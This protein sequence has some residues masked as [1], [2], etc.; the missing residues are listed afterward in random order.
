MG[1]TEERIV[2]RRLVLGFEMYGKL[3]DDPFFK[4]VLRDLFTRDEL[5]AYHAL[6]RD[7]IQASIVL[8]EAKQIREMEFR[9]QYVNPHIYV[10]GSITT[11]YLH[12]RRE[13]EEAA[14]EK[15]EL[16]VGSIFGAIA[17]AYAEHAWPNDLT[18]QV[19]FSE[20]VAQLGDTLLA[21]GEAIEARD[22]TR[23]GHFERTDPEPLGSATFQHGS[24]L[25]EGES[26]ASEASHSHSGVGMAT[27][28]DRDPAPPQSVTGDQTALG[29]PMMNSLTGTSVD[30]N[31]TTNGNQAWWMIEP[32]LEVC[33]AH[34]HSSDAMG[35]HDVV[36]AAQETE[37]PH[38]EEAPAPA[39]SDHSHHGSDASFHA[40]PTH[41]GHDCLGQSS[42]FNEVLMGGVDAPGVCDTHPHDGAGHGDGIFDGPIDGHG[43]GLPS[44]VPGD[45]DWCHADFQDTSHDHQTDLTW[46]APHECDATVDTHASY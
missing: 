21:L 24:T 23:H 8:E 12:E 17:V 36:H 5:Q 20:F 31:G 18:H 19:E 6:E 29:D 15:Y 38:T 43:D 40:G 30:S 11:E 9:D 16:S 1:A 3:R 34:G 45:A 33:D 2:H 46:D 32:A 7:Q 25:V 39:D 28:E 41:D 26:S 27:P 10:D 44:P 42:V 22:E 37:T 35:T 4:D 13:V 14:R